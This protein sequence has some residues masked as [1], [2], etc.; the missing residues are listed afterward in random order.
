MKTVSLLLL[1]LLA[2]CA[3]RP[4]ARESVADW[5]V[6]RPGVHQALERVVS[7]LQLSK[8]LILIED[9]SLPS[10]GLLGQAQHWPTHYLVLIDPALTDR[11]WTMVALHELAH[12]VVWDSG[13][14]ESEHGN[15]WGL[16]SGEVFR[17]WVGEPSP[18]DPQPVVVELGPGH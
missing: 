16:A 1:A 17:L 2:S 10:Q 12:V 11:E 3:A 4:L 14:M 6:E 9:P 15:L 5:T 7:E 18:W 8:D 13:S